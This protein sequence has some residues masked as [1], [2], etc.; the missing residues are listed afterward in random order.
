MTVPYPGE[1]FRL[2]FSDYYGDEG[3]PFARQVAGYFRRAG[4]LIRMPLGRGQRLGIRDIENWEQASSL[5]LNDF[6]EED[7]ADTTTA[8]AWAAHSGASIATLKAAMDAALQE[9]GYR[10]YD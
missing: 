2:R 6:G 10:L 8:A 7:L 9:M 3:I 1:H 4:N 5:F